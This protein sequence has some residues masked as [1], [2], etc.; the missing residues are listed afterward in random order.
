[1]FA[2]KKKMKTIENVRENESL[3]LSYFADGGI[4]NL[5]GVAEWHNHSGKQFDI[6][7]KN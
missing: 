3:Q 4:N 5:S 2:K 7:L 1:M 6:M